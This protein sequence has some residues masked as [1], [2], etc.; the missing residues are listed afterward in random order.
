M[1]QRGRA[2]LLRGGILVLWLVLMGLLIRFEVFPEIFTHT[3]P[4]YRSL[5][6]RDVLMEDSWMRIL[7]KAQPIGY[8]HT[9]VEIDEANPLKHYTMA[10]RVFVRLKAMGLDQPIYGDIVKC[11]GWEFDEHILLK[12][13]TRPSATPRR[14]IVP[15]G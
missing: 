15:P 6:D 11:C 13:F 8:S 4:G 12:L 3:L 7:Y 5:L 1:S 14:R 2:R 10:S 9:T